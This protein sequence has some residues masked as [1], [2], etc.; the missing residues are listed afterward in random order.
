[1][2]I[3]MSENEPAKDEEQIDSKVTAGK[4]ESEILG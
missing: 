3:S 4:L 1:M 2:L